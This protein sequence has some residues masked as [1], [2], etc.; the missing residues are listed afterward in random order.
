MQTQSAV[1]AT[2]E[3][4]S[5]LSFR[6]HS[7]L[8]GNA[9]SC[10]KSTEHV[11]FGYSNNS[12]IAVCTSASTPSIV[13]AISLRT[14]VPSQIAHASSTIVLDRQK[15]FLARFLITP[16]LFLINYFKIK[17]TAVLIFE[18]YISSLTNL[19]QYLLCTHQRLKAIFYG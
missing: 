10:G 5:R 3:T 12:T 18:I 15:A 9:I 13:I 8:F 11:R 2:T 4:F 7:A 14:L 19:K 1:M 16:I 17:R 6:L